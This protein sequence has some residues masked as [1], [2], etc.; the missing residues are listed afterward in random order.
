MP[1]TPE[2]F[3]KLV[4]KDDH[5]RLEN[6]VDQLNGKFDNMMDTLDGIAVGVKDIKSE[7]AA[8]LGA[9]D[10]FEERINKIEKQASSKSINK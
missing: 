9:H 8:N 5:N 3:N 6:K 2:E 1:L 10:R 7:Q 4:T